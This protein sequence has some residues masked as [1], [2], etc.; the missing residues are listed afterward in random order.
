VA[1]KF[2][3]GFDQPLLHT[4][5]VDKK[6]T[7]LNAVQTLSRLNRMLPPIKE[8]TMVLDFANEAEEIAVAFQ[9]YYDRTVLPEGTDPN[10]LY[11]LETR[12]GGHEVFTQA[13]VDRFAGVYFDPKGTQ[14]KLLAALAPAKDRF[15]AL[16]PEE[17]VEFRAALTD[18]VRL[19]AF[20]SQVLPFADA[21]LEKLYVYGRL[22]LRVLPVDRA[23]LPAEIMQQIDIDSY[24]VQK[25]GDGGIKLKPGRGELTPPGELPVHVL[26]PDP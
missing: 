23:A 8:E 1:E 17:Q 20:L 2:Q 12:L 6:L 18:Y 13:E 11:D 5:Y 25:T 24:R 10:K 16:A 26:K 3:T 19:Y 21:G 9:P 14:A 22:L 7:G 4:M 15:T